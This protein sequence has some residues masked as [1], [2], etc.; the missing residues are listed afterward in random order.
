MIDIP[1]VFC[2]HFV[3]Q[4]FFIRQL[5]CKFKSKICLLCTAYGTCYFISLCLSVEVL[6]T[7]NDIIN[8]VG[9]MSAILVFVSLLT[10]LLLSFLR[11]FCLFIYLFERERERER[12]EKGGRKIWM[13]KRNIDW[14]P[15]AYNPGMC[16]VGNHT[17][18][19]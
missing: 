9:F 12:E 17:I 3:W 16:P 4:I 15:V 6:F 5:V 8:V 18:D 13:C 7:F 19:F 11:R 14:L 1:V 2:F 10:T